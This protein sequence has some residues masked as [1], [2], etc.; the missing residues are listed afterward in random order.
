M[1]LDSEVGSQQTR[2]LHFLDYWRVIRSRKEIVLAVAILVI[3]TGTAYTMMLPNMYRS[4]VRISISEDTPTVD[5]IT[6]EQQLYMYNPYFIST[7]LEIMKSSQM[8]EKVIERLD[9]QTVWGRDGEKLAIDQAVK[10]LKSRM[11]IV[12]GRDTSVV[13][14]SVKL[15]D[16]TLAAKIANTFADVY[17]DSRINLAENEDRAAIKKMEEQ[18]AEQGVRVM[19]A[20]ESL[21]KVRKE[22]NIASVGG[23]GN[24]DIDEYKMQQMLSESLAAQREMLQG[25]ATLEI[26][27]NLGDDDLVES[28]S[29]V[30]TD[31]TVMNAVRQIADIENEISALSAEYGP[32]HPERIRMENRKAKETEF[33]NKKLSGM[34]RRLQTEY[35]LAKRTY[36]DMNAQLEA[37][38][39]ET[40]DMQGERYRPFRKAL[41]DLERARMIYDQLGS[42]IRQQII[43]NAAPK[44]PVEIFDRA[45]IDR[46]P[47]SPNHFTNVLISIFVGFGAG[48]GLAY[49][50]EYL[51]T[52]IKSSEDIE[53][54][55]GLPVLGLIPQKVRPLIEE[56]PDSEHAE[57]YRVLRTNLAFSESGSSRGAFCVLSSGAGE[58]KSTTCFNLAYVCAQQGEK[59]LLIDADL[60]RPVQHTILGVSNRFGLTNVLLRDVPVE[61][62][63]KATSVPNLH[64]LPSGRLPRT[65]LGVLDPKRIGELV[66]SLKQKYDVV[67]IDTPP[68]VGISDSSVIAKEADGAIIVVQYRKYPRDMVAKAK[69]MIEALG[70]KVVGAVL[71]NINVMRDDYYY[72]YHSY[73]SDYY[74][75]SQHELD[76]DSEI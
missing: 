55:L 59:V 57:S 42:R 53:Q 4:V 6:G 48:I 47:V 68:L 72:Y 45:V 38:K 22:L 32:H 2:G 76:S 36:D 41:G 26:L 16:A 34:R 24:I 31:P 44:N 21:H 67:M 7:Q 19:D 20:E 46:R 5:P 58:G 37:V 63:I 54:L 33:L 27:N 43:R 13:N 64:F 29:A 66:A 75:S 35:D 18:L 51:D 10:V 3:I 69:Q 71:N 61:E 11:D 8:F 39:K 50:I 52:T 30:T 65:S 15:D 25:A 9:L 1:S 12:P 60:R 23:E 73:Y 17:R 62:A 40:I 70:V 28:A 49:F 74:R 14:I 56:G